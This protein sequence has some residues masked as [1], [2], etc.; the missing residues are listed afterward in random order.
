MK[1]K[2]SSLCGFISLPFLLSLIH[3]QFKIKWKV[4]EQYRVF[5]LVTGLYTLFFPTLFSTITCQVM[6]QSLYSSPF[7]TER[8]SWGRHFTLRETGNIQEGCTTKD[9]PLEASSLGSFPGEIDGN[10]LHGRVCILEFSKILF[11]DW[12]YTQLGRSYPNTIQRNNTLGGVL[13]SRGMFFHSYVKKS[14]LFLALCELCYLGKLTSFD[15]VEFCAKTCCL[16][17][18]L[19]AEESLNDGLLNLHLS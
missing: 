4:R 2:S 9:E 10:V 17:Q 12:R 18:E 11:L 13:S 16:V 19:P 7:T 5:M 6:K 3:L 1:Q 14:A 8:D 15:R